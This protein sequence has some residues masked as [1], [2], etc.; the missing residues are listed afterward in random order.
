MKFH[1]KSNSRDIFYPSILAIL[2]CI[3]FRTF[4]LN[5]TIDSFDFASI[6]IV[7]F[8]TVC[9]VRFIQTNNNKI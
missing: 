6:S 8:L 1:L 3:T 5:S 9:I 2:L 7:S 4:S